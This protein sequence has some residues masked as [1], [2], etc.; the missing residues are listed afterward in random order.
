MSVLEYI[1]CVTVEVHLTVEVLQR[2]CL[3]GNS[4]TAIV[5]GPVDEVLEVQV[6]LN[7]AAREFGFLVDSRGESRSNGPEPKEDGDRRQ[8][9]DQEGCHEAST[10]FP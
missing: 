7:G 4:V 8:K 6:V 1:Q 5:L 3:N 2:E 10:D 9:G